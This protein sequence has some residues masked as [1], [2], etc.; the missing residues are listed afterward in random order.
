MQKPIERLTRE[1]MEEKYPDTWL[2]LTNIKWLEDGANFESA[3]VV[4]TDKDKDEL[5]GIQMKNS[6]FIAW[7]TGTD[8][9]GFMPTMF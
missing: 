3:V 6:D 2:G 4:Y 5:I 7:Y 8:D 1:E 9:D